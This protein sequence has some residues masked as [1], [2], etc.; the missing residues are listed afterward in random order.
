[1]GSEISKPASDI[2]V[3]LV[4][5][6]LIITSS[7]N[8]DCLGGLAIDVFGCV[9]ALYMF[10]GDNVIKRDLFFFFGIISSGSDVITGMDFFIFGFFGSTLFICLR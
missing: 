1:M 2:P 8:G 9:S 4:P 6:L 3:G 10:N 5:V 7:F